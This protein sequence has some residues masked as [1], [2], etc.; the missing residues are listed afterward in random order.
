MCANG[1]RSGSDGRRFPNTPA[2][3]SG[4]YERG[5]VAVGGVQGRAPG[6]AAVADDDRGRAGHDRAFVARGVAYSRG[7][8]SLDDHG[9]RARLDLGRSSAATQ[10]VTDARC[11]SAL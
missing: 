6:A 9:G 2:P 8:A 3:D 1:A 11:W 7:L 5:A 4:P 10:L